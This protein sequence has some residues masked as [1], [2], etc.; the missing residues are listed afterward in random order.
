MRHRKKTAKSTAG[1]KAREKSRSKAAGATSGSGAETRVHKRILIDMVDPEEL[2]IAVLESGRLEEI[3]VEI[4]ENKAF[5]GNIYKGRIVNLEP[6]I[7]AAFV[8]IG[9]G[10][11]AFLHVSDVLP[12][13]SGAKAIPFDS[14]SKRPSER[15]RPLGQP[16]REVEVDDLYQRSGKVPR[17]H[18]RRTP[19][20][21]F[22]AHTGSRDSL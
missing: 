9:I 4:P 19:I 17:A 6:A 2:R 16:T 21:G 7:Q 11:N 22:E 3:S 13:Y 10:R 20:R 5:V 18:A 14:L 12:V 1:A 15:K 8:D